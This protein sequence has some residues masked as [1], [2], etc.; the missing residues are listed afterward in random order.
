MDLAICFTN[1]GPYHLARLRALAAALGRSGGR[2]IAYEAA[3][4]ERRYPWQTAAGGRAV[5]VG[6][7]SSPTASSRRSPAPPARGRC[8]EALDR[9]RPDA[10]GIV[11]YAR[12]ESMAALG[13]AGATGGR[14]S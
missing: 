6:H 2:L 8:R 7:A 12:P 9:D 13:W 5:R 14:R 3:G 4:T 1:F 11:G 10:V